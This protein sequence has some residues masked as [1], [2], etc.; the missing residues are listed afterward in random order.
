MKFIHTADIHL[1]AA[2]L[3][4]NQLFE[5]F[6]RII[7]DAKNEKVDVLM[8]SGDLFNKQPLLKELRE[9]NALF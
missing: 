6:E 5:S 7:E 4:K 2:F 8:I 3:E 1:G 9:I